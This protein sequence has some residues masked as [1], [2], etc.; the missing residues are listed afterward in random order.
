MVIFE[1]L[2][3]RVGKFEA[4]RDVADFALESCMIGLELSD[5]V[6]DY[7]RFLVKGAIQCFNF[8]VNVVEVGVHF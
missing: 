6:E 8:V 5:G 1:L 3:L 4:L 2:N 7:S